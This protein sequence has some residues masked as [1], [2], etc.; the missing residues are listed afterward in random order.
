MQY[1]FALDP[2]LHPKLPVTLE[3]EY[4]NIGKEP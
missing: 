2:Q 4:Q 1:M 3:L